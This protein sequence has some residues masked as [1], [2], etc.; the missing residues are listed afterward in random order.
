[1]S[2]QTWAQYNFSRGKPCL[3]SICEQFSPNATPLWLQKFFHGKRHKEE[4]ICVHVGYC[5]QLPSLQREPCCF[6]N[7]PPQRDLEFLCAVKPAPLVLLHP[8]LPYPRLCFL[9]PV[10]ISVTKR[11]AQHV[12]YL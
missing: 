4:K 5:K 11:T 6:C 7:F 12:D 9:M 2:R 8:P 10:A 3:N 1:M